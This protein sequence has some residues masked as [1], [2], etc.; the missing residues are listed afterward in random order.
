MRFRALLPAFLVAIVSI[1]AA[2][3]G[4]AQAPDPGGAISVPLPPTDRMDPTKYE[5]PELAGAIPADGSQLVDG[6][7]PEPLVDYVIHVGQH[8]QSL[9]LFTNG[10]IVI[11]MKGIDGGM[12]KKVTIPPDALVE[13]RKHLNASALEQLASRASSMSSDRDYELIRIYD[14]SEYVERRFAPNLI[15]PTPVQRQRRI[16]LDV[17]SAIAYDREVTAPLVNYVPT[18]GDIL[19]SE[20]QR[21]YSVKRIIDNH[22]VELACTT[23]PT[24]MYV[25][26]KDLHLYFVAVRRP[27][28]D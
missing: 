13:Y 14:G 4:L 24:V 20:D 8:E 9:T 27:R 17:F 10:L 2:A 19:V 1:V 22:V 18:Q 23:E 6:R 15:L 12:L 28:P 7:L 3:D 5:I 25:D 16:L 21:V 26:F 11:R